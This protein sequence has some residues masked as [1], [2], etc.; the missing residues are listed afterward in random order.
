MGGT[1][2]CD[3]LTYSEIE[4]RF[5]KEAKLRKS[6]KLSYRYPRGTSS[7]FFLFSSLP[8]WISE[9]R[10]RGECQLI[11]FIKHFGLLMESCFIINANGRI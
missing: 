5:P 3:G 8:M 7:S 9:R 2:A 6:D 4:Q 10:K 11:F 1:G